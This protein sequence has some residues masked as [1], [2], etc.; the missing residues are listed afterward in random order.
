MMVI[1]AYVLYWDLPLDRIE[2]GSP[3][4]MILTEAPRR[5]DFVRYQLHQLIGLARGDREIVDLV[6]RF[7]GSTQYDRLPV[8]LFSLEERPPSSAAD[9]WR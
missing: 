5:R 4:A 6:V 8:S 7:I 2:F 9:W 3:S 1:S